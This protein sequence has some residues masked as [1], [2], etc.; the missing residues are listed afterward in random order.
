[1]LAPDTAPDLSVLDGI[2]RIITLNKYDY[3]LLMKRAKD[4]P[5]FTLYV[6]DSLDDYWIE[7][8][9]MEYF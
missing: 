7:K 9:D 1:M 8:F 5:Y 6:T 2:N 3:L 4:K